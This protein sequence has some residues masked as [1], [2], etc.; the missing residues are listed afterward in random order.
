M[1]S[2][3]V[4]F[5]CGYKLQ[6]KLQTPEADRLSTSVANFIA[7]H[8]KSE[9][10]RI[11]MCWM[12]TVSQPL[13][14]S[15]SLM[16]CMIYVVAFSL[17]SCTFYIP[18]RYHANKSYFEVL[19]FDMK[20]IPYLQRRHYFRFVSLVP[21]VWLQQEVIFCTNT[22]RIF[23]RTDGVNNVPCSLSAISA[24]NVIR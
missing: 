17:Q 11:E 15:I 7:V 4:G 3:A 21:G 13:P 8:R 24:E 9:H 18:V 10:R 1:R 23:K 2:N 6:Q 14:R 22:D 16:L 12:Y 19:F 5:I 20:Q